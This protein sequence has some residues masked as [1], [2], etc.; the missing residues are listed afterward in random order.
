[1]VQSVSETAVPEVP[2]SS[3]ENPSQGWS[4]KEMRQWTKCLAQS[5]SHSGVIII[6]IILEKNKVAGPRL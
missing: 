5:N 3:P 4:D 1:M 6:E 2:I